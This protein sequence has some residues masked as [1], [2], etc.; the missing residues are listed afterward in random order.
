MSLR[1]QGELFKFS[2][3]E[4]VDRE[5][6][7]ISPR[8]ISGVKFLLICLA[9][10]YNEKTGQ[11]NPSITTLSKCIEKSTSQTTVCMNALKRLG[12]VSVS[13]NEKGG[14]YTPHYQIHI[15]SHPTDKGASTLEETVAQN[16][17]VTT[18]SA[19]PNVVTCLQ[20]A[21]PFIDRTRTLRDPLD[22]PLIKSLVYERDA[23]IKREGLIRLG[24]KYKY[25]FKENTAINELELWLTS[26]IFP[27][28]LH[29]KLTDHA[30][31]H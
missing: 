4:Y 13:R 10:F 16:V 30:Y 28:T 15:P 23:F 27:T 8:L 12:L 11:C 20:D 3:E 1:L 29:N 24:K 31:K 14:R 21:T 6:L 26:V 17:S 2:L 19:E 7:D 5:G 9:N 22:E 25:P 18:H